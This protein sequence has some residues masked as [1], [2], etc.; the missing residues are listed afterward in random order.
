MKKEKD[1][2]TDES[3]LKARAK[4]VARQAAAAN[5]TSA[6]GQAAL[7]EAHEREMDASQWKKV[8]D[9]KMRKVHEEQLKLT[10]LHGEIIERERRVNETRRK[11]QHELRETK[12]EVG[13]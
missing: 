11:K 12:Q 13:E 1:M 4:E 9:E 7:Q 8:S 5:E 2:Q 3:R 6:R 10:A